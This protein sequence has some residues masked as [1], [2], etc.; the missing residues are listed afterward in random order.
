[1]P[2]QP[3]DAIQPPTIT[4]S[5]VDVSSEYL[6]DGQLTVCDV[7]YGALVAYE[8]W[9]VFRGKVFVEY[10][11]KTA[12]LVLVAIYAVFDVFGGIAGEVV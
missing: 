5:L 4:V 7:S 12:G 1:M 9:D 8:V 3:A 6:G 11:V 2:A 10:T